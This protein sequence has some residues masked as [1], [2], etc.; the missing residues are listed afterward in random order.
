MRFFHVDEWFVGMNICQISETSGVEFGCNEQLTA[1]SDFART[2]RPNCAAPCGSAFPSETSALA[3]PVV[4]NADVVT[5][6][7]TVDAA[8]VMKVL[9]DEIISDA[10]DIEKAAPWLHRLATIARRR[11][12]FI[13]NFGTYKDSIES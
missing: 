11:S 1:K 4:C 6:A 12:V 5:T 10:I 2:T 9:R 7:A 8:F 13:F 3:A